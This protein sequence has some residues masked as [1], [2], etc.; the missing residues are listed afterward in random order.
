PVEGAQP[1]RRTETE[2]AARSDEGRSPSGRV[3]PAVPLRAP[4]RAPRRRIFRALPAWSPLAAGGLIAASLLAFLMLRENPLR[5]AV[6]S[7]RP[8]PSMP[9]GHGDPDTLQAPSDRSDRD[10]YVTHQAPRDR[11]GPE[12]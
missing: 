1:S 10:G 11:S 12:E 5:Q 7:P 9:S 8:A 2:T 4:A 3:A 6:L